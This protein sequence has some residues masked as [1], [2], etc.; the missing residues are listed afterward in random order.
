MG[1]MLNCI[2]N[3]RNVMKRW[4]AVMLAIF[5]RRKCNST[6]LMTIFAMPIVTNPIWSRGRIIIGLE[7]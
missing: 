7:I 6:K 3:E 1:Y 5:F 4:L 2:K